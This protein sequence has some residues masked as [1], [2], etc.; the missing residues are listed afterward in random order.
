MLALL[1]VMRIILTAGYRD[2]DQDH[3]RPSQGAIGEQ[4]ADGYEPPVDALGVIEAVDPQ[5]DH[6]RAAELIPELAGPSLHGRVRGPLDQRSRVDRYRERSDPRP[7]P[8][9]VQ[10]RSEEHTSE[11]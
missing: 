8:G 11:L 4:L 9:V 1:T 6:V 5:Q 2:L 7:A 10:H 3:P